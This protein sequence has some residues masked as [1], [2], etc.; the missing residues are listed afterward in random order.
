MDW[1]KDF[2]SFDKQLLDHTLFTI[3]G[4]PITLATLA[5][6][7]L[8]LIVTQVIA[9]AVS[10]S[11]ARALALRKVQGK[12]TVEVAEKLLHYL[13]LVTGLGIGLQTIGINLSA[14]FAAGAVFA[15]G[16]GFAMQNIMQN[17]VAGVILLTERT[18]TPGDIIEVEGRIVRVQK[19]GIRS[20]LARTRDEEEIIIPNASIV[21]A[22]V[23]N[24][25]LR[26]SLYRLR[27]EVGVTYDSDMKLVEKVLGQVG[28]GV[29]CRE[30]DVEPVVL[31]NGF[32][33]SSVDWEVSIWITDPWRVLNA[34]S[35]L[36][37]A[38]W[39]G[40]KDAGIVIAFPQL[41]VHFDPPPAEPPVPANWPRS[42]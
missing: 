23:T 7:V 19:L 38:I 24:Y 42:V 16:L 32:G 27:C 13:I 14:L 21:Q 36:N 41:D 40:L 28:R 35:D 37:K 10:K 18:V 15:I 6:F 22:P 31:L 25:T 4:T 11:V 8:I 29:E 39:W 33:S 3:A 12:G 2:L 9:Y 20:T 30:K 1:F 17:F 26:D 5:V 34:R